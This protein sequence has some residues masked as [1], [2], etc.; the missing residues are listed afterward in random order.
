VSGWGGGGVEKSGGWNK[1]LILFSFLIHEKL[2]LI[3]Y[4]PSSSVFLP[5][6]LL[7]DLKKK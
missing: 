2:G 7:I 1:T 3:I 5:L 6:K 4:R